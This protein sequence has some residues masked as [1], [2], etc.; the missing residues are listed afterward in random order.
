MCEAFRQMPVPHDLKNRILARAKTIRPVRQWR[1]PA[2]IAAAAALAFLLGLA[3]FWVRPEPENSL[4]TFRSRMVRAVLRQYSMGI[5]TSDMMQVRHFLA[6]NNAPADYVLPQGL[7]RA[8]T[9]GAGLLSWQDR[10]VSM[11]CLEG[12]NRDTLFLFVVDRDSVKP[13]PPS[14]PQFAQVSKLMTASWSQ[15]GKVYVLAASKENGE[16]LPKL[17]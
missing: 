8:P 13:P 1:Q 10:R 12:A 11:V 7:A 2:W 15:G 17:F 4:D 16:A 3:A 9:L 5:E 14:A 6:T